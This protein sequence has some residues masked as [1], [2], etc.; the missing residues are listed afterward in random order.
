MKV[1]VTGGCERIRDNS[2]RFS[3]MRKAWTPA[4]WDDGFVDNRGRFRVYRPDCP[5]AYE[6][7]YALRAHVVWWLANGAHA[8]GT[9]LHHLDSD[10]LNDRLE[11]LAL[12][13]H[14]AHSRL[15]NP[16]RNEKVCPTCGEMFY[17][18]K[19]PRAKY[20]SLA[21]YHAMPKS[22]TTR[23]RTSASLQRAY[24]EGRR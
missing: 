14:G 18:Q 23:A 24:A 3:R 12:L 15:H 7:G 1:L 21:C 9:N 22:A 6:D 8:E 2:G 16:R 17:R 11:N 10:R 5:R 20:C 4:N 19:K 13:D